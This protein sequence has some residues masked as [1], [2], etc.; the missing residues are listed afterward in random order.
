MSRRLALILVSLV[1]TAAV[2]TSTVRAGI[3]PH[4][5]SKHHRQVG[6]GQIKFDGLGPER[7][8]HRARVWHQAY[9]RQRRTLLASTSVREAITLAGATYGNS[10]TLWRKARCESGFNPF[11]HNASGASGL[12]QFIPST[13]ASTPYRG[14]SIWSPYANALAAGWMHEHGRGGEWVCQ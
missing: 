2:V 11:A 10:A 6:Y 13:F 12:F 1:F 3:D 14:L 9:L 8:A 4:A 5:K 7:W